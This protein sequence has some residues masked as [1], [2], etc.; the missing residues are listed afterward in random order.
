MW[1][2]KDT[3]RWRINFKV[4]PNDSHNETKIRVGHL[5][6]LKSCCS[7]WIE[8][9]QPNETQEKKNDDFWDEFLEINKLI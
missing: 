3:E 6:T 5:N 4:L 1:T 9:S 8:F 2:K 7:E